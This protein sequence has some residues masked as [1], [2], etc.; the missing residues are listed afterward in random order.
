MENANPLN[1]QGRPFRRRNGNRS[2]IR[3]LARQNSFR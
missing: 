3:T 2:E 1:P